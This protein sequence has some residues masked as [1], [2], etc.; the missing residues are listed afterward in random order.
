[1]LAALLSFVWGF[2]CGAV[3]LAAGELSAL[4]SFRTH[5]YMYA[6]TSGTYFTA[7]W[8]AMPPTSAWARA[9]TA[10]WRRWRRRRPRAGGGRRRERG[11]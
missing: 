1:M 5:T 7:Q 2:L 11:R 8:G 9:K 6:H 4:S 10:R 3:L